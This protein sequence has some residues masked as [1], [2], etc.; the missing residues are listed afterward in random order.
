M[1]VEL[2]RSPDIQLLGGEVVLLQGVAA[3]D[4]YILVARGIKITEGVDGIAAP[5]RLMQLLAALKAAADAA[6][7][8]RPDVADIADV[9]QPSSSGTLRTGERVGVE[10]V[11]QMC[12]VGVR[13]ARRLAPSLGGVKTTRGWQF[14][15][16][17]VQVYLDAQGART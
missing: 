15:R 11:A 3:V 1:R 6:G 9:R 17:L 5:P 2:P 7:R 13:Q 12:N 16:G 8:S 14:D 10:E 4:A